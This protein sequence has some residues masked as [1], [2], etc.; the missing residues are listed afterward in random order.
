M[1]KAIDDQMY[2]RKNWSENGVMKM[3]IY[4]YKRKMKS[5]KLK[6]SLIYSTGSLPVSLPENILSCI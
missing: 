5:L 1:T 2:V 3:L 6:T 4:M